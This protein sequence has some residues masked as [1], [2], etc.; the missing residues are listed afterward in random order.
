M[1]G[2]ELAVM[3]IT[4]YLRSY[5]RFP[6]LHT[7]ATRHWPGV[8]LVAA[9]HIAAL[10]RLYQTEFGWFGQGLFLL[11]WLFLNCFWLVILRRPAVAAALSFALFELL[12]LVSQFKFG[13]TWMT[14]TFLDVMV[15]DPDSLAFLLSV[16][17]GLRWTVGA[18]VLLGVVLLLAIWW[19]DSIRIRRAVAAGTGAAALA[20]IVLLSNAIS[21][22]PWEPFQGVNHV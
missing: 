13:I 1:L 5:S 22:N 9:I 7:I 20:G 11:T 18:F 8:A 17:P 3:S 2:A 15:I 19:F 16:T 6:G 12:I 21:E 14:A 4:D 10:V